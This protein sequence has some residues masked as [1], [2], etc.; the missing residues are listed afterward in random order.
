MAENLID[1]VVTAKAIVL[2]RLKDV[3]IEDDFAVKVK[4]LRKPEWLGLYRSMSQF[5]S[6]RKVI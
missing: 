5:K 6:I 3:G 1:L 2:Q 4:T